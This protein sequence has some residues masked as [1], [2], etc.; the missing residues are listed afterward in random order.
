MMRIAD[1][2]VLMTILAISCRRS[3]TCGCR[4]TAASQAVCAWNSAGKLILNSTFSIT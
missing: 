1:S 2:W 4:V 3:L